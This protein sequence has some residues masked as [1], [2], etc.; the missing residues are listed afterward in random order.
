MMWLISRP[1]MHKHDNA[2]GETT[3][4]TTA[5]FSQGNRKST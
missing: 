2:P 4:I 3:V 5:L 1:E